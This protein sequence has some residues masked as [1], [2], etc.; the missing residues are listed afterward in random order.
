MDG[1]GVAWCGGGRLFAMSQNA[2]GGFAAQPPGPDGYIGAAPDQ[3]QS[4][5]SAVTSSA[6]PLDRPW[7]P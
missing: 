7:W 5:A 4:G 2:V 3:G 6:G 1:G